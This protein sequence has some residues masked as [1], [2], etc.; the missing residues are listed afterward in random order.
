MTDL[1]ILLLAPSIAT[2]I[3]IAAD[4]V[5]KHFLYKQFDYDT[6]RMS[7]WQVLLRR[8][9]ARLG[10]D[11]TRLDVMKGQLDENTRRLDQLEHRIDEIMIVIRVQ[12]GRT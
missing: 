9:P 7:L 1:E 3:L 12:T 5:Y 4:I 11:D 10:H 2:W 6:R 8:L